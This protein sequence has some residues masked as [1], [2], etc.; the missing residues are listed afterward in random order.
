MA[1]AIVINKAD[2]ANIKQANLAKIEFAR[3]LH[4]Y[5]LKESSWQPKVETCSA[6]DNTNIDTVWKII[7]EYIELTKST[8]YFVQQ[9]NEQ[10]K[11]WLLE[12]INQQLKDNFYSNPDIKKELATL[13]KK[14]ND[15]KTSPFI[16]AKSLLALYHKKREH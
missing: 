8:N 13:L 1:D 15:S 6:L 10:N 4:L 7:Q 3:A 11:F 12:T 9:R 5:P 16:A 14:V 2:G